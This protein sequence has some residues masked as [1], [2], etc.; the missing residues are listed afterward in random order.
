MELNVPQYFFDDSLIDHHEGLT[1]RWLPAT[2]FPKPVIE[3]DRPWESRTLVLF[4]TV[5][6]HPTDGYRLYYTSWP[7]SLTLPSRICLATSRDGFR[8]HKPSLGLVEFEGSRDNNIVC[9]PNRVLDSASVAVDAGDSA[10]PY[11]MMAFHMDSKMVWNDPNWGLYGQVSHDGLRWTE[12]PHRLLRAGDRTNLMVHRVD[13]RFIAYT[14]HPD[15]IG[16]FGRRVIY[17]AESEDFIHWTEA[18]PILLPDLSDE[19]D[20]EFYGMSVFRRHG[21]YIGLLEYWRSS[22]DT[23]EIHLVFSRD[24]KRWSRPHPR[25]PFI[26]PAFDW[27]RT[28]N[29]CASNGPIIINDQMVFYVGGRWTA[30]GY[31]AAQQYGS[32]GF[33]S[34][35]LDRFCA[36]EGV[37]GGHF[38]TP[39][40][41]W[42]EADLQL[43][44]DARDTFT[45]YPGS[46]DGL[47]EVE[48]LDKERRLLPNWSGEQRAQFRTNTHSR[49]RVLSGLVRW[50][51]NR[52]LRLLAKQTIRFRFTLRHARLFT[53]EAR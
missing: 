47:I 1:R 21:W 45:S 11:K 7:A 30:H 25:T 20:V 15:M 5:I 44:A 14:R 50:P 17:R 46:A 3:A 18:E 34:L 35:G 9:V 31:D 37:A 27:N 52:S 43:N 41:E 32:I 42:Q 36:L 49:N 53:L 48:V 29:S 38:V 19:P 12:L 23:F 13:G 40:I 26:A 16:R 6:E 2:V 39:P 24:G 10:S 33:A 8:W 22:I 51:E 4:G 28:W